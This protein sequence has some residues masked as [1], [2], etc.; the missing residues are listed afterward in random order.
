MPE[1]RE[2]TARIEPGAIGKASQLFDTTWSTLFNELFQNA[3]RAGASHVKIMID[4]N[5]IVVSDDGYGIENPE[6]VLALGGSDWNNASASENP[7]GMGLFALAGRGDG[8]QVESRPLTGRPWKMKLD[9]DHFDGRKP[10]SAVFTERTGATDRGTLIAIPSKGYSNEAHDA[11]QECALFLPLPVLINDKPAEREDFMQKAV[12]VLHHKGIRIGVLDPEARRYRRFHQGRN[13]NFH[14]VTAKGPAVRLNGRRPDQ[15]NDLDWACYF[16]A[17]PEGS[18]DLVLPT[19]KRV[20]ETPETAELQRTAM[21]FLWETALNAEPGLEVDIRTYK[22]AK[23]LGVLDVRTP[24]RRL[25]HWFP[26]TADNDS[27]GS[28][29]RETDHGPL[30][31]PSGTDDEPLILAEPDKIREPDQT[32]LY[33]ALRRAGIAKRVYAP[34]RLLPG[35]DW[36]EN[37]N[38]IERVEMLFD[39][40]DRTYDVDTMRKSADRPDGAAENMRMVL[41][42][43]RGRIRFSTDILFIDDDCSDDVDPEML[44][45]PGT[46]LAPQ[47]L[48][49]LLHDAYYSADLDFDAESVGTQERAFRRNALRTARERLGSPED[50]RKLAIE[51]TASD[52]I[53]AEL[54]S[55]ESVTVSRVPE[56]DIVA[57]FTVAAAAAGGAAKS[58][59]LT[60]HAP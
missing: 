26:D 32:V 44:I 31:H 22:N 24:E 50:A 42:L 5:R 36:Y 35:Y 1:T 16:D 14:G 51:E 43:T 37:V 59:G 60:E 10:A 58:D 34:D 9:K 3:R 30:E 20:R 29:A 12:A 47:E 40:G 46:D 4:E 21:V 52:A 33:R 45:T 27:D 13:Y 2:I 39:E 55:G 6:I 23:A 48:A 19:R 15:K 41:H 11:A 38:R 25:D 54:C 49:D 18:I 53:G 56:G 57:V 17:T 7:A 28:Q 8:C